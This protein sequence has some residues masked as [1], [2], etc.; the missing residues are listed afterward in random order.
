MGIT[1]YMRVWINIEIHIIFFQKTTE[2]ILRVI[3]GRLSTRKHIDTTTINLQ[4][5]QS[6]L[7]K[8]RELRHLYMA[9]VSSFSSFSQRMEPA[10]KSVILLGYMSLIIVLGAV[11]IY[12]KEDVQFELSH[13]GVMARFITL[14][15]SIAIKIYSF[16][17]IGSCVSISSTS[18]NISFCA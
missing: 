13:H 5:T 11:V 6:F 3:Q 14:Y 12:F 2:Q 17:R 16:D 7:N 4:S 1:F 15:I 10:V 8:L 9:T 18:R